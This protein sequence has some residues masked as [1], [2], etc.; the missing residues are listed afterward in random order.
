VALRPLTEADLLLVEP[1]YG[2]A[3]AASAGLPTGQPEANLRRHLEEARA[4]PGRELLAITVA[5]G[6]E[7]VGILDRWALYPAAG[8]LTTG[9]LAVAEPHRGRGFG[10]EAILTLEKES[11]RRGLAHRFA[12]G[13]VAEAGRALYFWLRLGYRP[14]LQAD[15]PWPSPRKGVV[16]M[17][18]DAE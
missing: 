18:R 16:W 9:F 7:L 15:L 1:W 12:A 11:R 3:A 6:G 5:G 4:Q 17:V 8:W 10:G 13:V 2:R 14:L